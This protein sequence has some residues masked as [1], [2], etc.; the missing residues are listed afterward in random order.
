MAELKPCRYCGNKTLLEVV[1]IVV[2][3]EDAYQVRCLMCDARGPMSFER[4]EAIE[5]WNKRGNMTTPT[6]EQLDIVAEKVKEML[7]VPNER[8]IALVAIAE[9]EKIR[10]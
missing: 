8:T 3:S 1:E 9:W 2:L 5:A 4:A 7:L 6:K 10:S